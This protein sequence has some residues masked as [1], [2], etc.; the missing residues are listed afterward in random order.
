MYVQE[1]GHAGGDRQISCAL[2]VY[3][4]SDLHKKQHAMS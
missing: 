2:L 1:S 3:S 4:R